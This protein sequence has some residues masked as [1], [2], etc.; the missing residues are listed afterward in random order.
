MHRGL[1]IDITFVAIRPIQRK[2]CASIEKTSPE[3]RIGY[4]FS[5]FTFYRKMWSSFWSLWVPPL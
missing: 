4:H 1:S 5:I 3:S 2:I